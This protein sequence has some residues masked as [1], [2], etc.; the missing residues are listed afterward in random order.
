M[1]YR[2]RLAARLQRRILAALPPV[3]VPATE[4]EMRSPEWCWTHQCHRSQCP[5]H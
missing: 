4:D 3:P 1:T 2:E 5:Q